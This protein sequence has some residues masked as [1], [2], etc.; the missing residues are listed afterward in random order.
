MTAHDFD[1]TS[2][3]GERLPLSA[4]RDKSVLIANTASLCEF[5]PQYNG[6]QELWERY[7]DRGLVVIAVPS[8]D[9]GDQEPGSADEIKA[10][11]RT[12]FEVT[13]P[14]TEKQSV[15]GAGAHPFFQWIEEEFSEAAAPRWNFHKYLIAPDGTLIGAWP[16]RVPPTSDEIIDLIEETLP[17]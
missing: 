8:N 4:W 13:F 1:F 7:R 6:L 3:D 11:C 15:I 5:T 16:S 14:L 17:G 2:I 12:K 9:F 10:F